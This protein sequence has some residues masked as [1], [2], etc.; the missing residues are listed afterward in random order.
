MNS[1]PREECGVVAIWTPGEE[2][3]AE[4]AYWAL[5]SLQHRGQEAAGVASWNNQEIQIH[6]RTGLVHSALSPE[7]LAEMKGS[8]AVGH[9][10]YSTTGESTAHNAGPVEYNGERHTTVAHNGNLVGAGKIKQQLLE[11]GF[12]FNTDTD[13]ELLAALL[14]DGD[15]LQSAAAHA[16]EKIKGAY[17]FA[18]LSQGQIVAGRDRW[19]IRP[20]VI[21]RLD[22]G[23]VLAS[24][25]CALDMLGATFLRE[26]VPGE[27]VILDQN[28]LH[29]EQLLESQARPCSFEQIYFARPDSKMAGRV[30]YNTRIELGRQLAK[31]YPVEA[32]LVIPVPD[33]GQLMAI[34]YAQKSGIQFGEGLVKNRY[35]GRTFI[36]PTPEQRAIALRRKFNTLPG[37]ICGQRLVVVDDSLVRGSTMRHLI[38]MLKEAGAEEVH[39]RIASPPTRHPC[40]YGIDMGRPGE[41]VAL[42]DEGQVRPADEVG[43]LVG[44]DSLHYLSLPGLSRALKQPL[45]E[46]CTACFTGQYPIPG[47]WESKNGLKELD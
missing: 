26:V 36:E 22:S 38:G 37:A 10:R 42:D 14:S 40:H 45:G 1:K 21:G 23:Y 16:M 46:L 27:M 7:R 17:A 11:H 3:A 28:G 9:V 32:D 15:S 47:E 41:Y 30:V 5:M 44:A 24:E 31:D 39:V 34:G 2:R 6:K 33:S 4:L 43:K 29:S 8:L 35:V 25:T 12:E 19:G 18:A 13:S 20:L